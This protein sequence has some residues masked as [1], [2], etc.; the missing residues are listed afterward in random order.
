MR[1]ST[2]TT[3]A[4]ELLREHERALGRLYRTYAECFAGQSEFW[5]RLAAEEDQHA[6]WLGSLR[7]RLEDDES[8]R[9]L[10]R[11]PTG[12]IEHSLVYVNKLIAN[13]H[14]SGITP[15]RALSVALDLE[16]ALL[17]SR[18]FEVFE[19]DSPELKRTLETLAES[20]HAHL[21]AVRNAWQTARETCEN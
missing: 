10:D 4:L 8:G 20:T 9:L 16:Q 15:L 21:A 19:S 3:D 12:A 11:F 6:E 14:T 5:L 2:T 18:Y 7:L 13:A 1:I 17:E